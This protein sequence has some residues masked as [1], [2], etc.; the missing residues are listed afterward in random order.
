MTFVSKL[1]LMTSPSSISIQLFIYIWTVDI[2]WFKWYDFVELTEEVLLCRGDSINTWKINSS[3]RVSSSHCLPNFR[4]LNSV[5]ALEIRDTLQAIIDSAN[6]EKK[7][8]L[9]MRKWRNSKTIISK[10]T[11]TQSVI[12]ITAFSSLILSTLPN[13]TASGWENWKRCLVLARAIFLAQRRKYE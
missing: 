11:W 13:L 7:T 12:L 5:S 1:L 6:T 9:G 4:F 10:S 3:I 2:L 8:P